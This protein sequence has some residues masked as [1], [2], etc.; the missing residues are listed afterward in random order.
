MSQK[1]LTESPK[2]TSAA[3]PDSRKLNPTSVFRVPILSTR[4]P[5]KNGSAT[6]GALSA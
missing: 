3:A 4:I 6:F 1:D 5:P 2:A